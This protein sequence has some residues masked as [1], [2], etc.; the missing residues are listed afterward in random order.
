MLQLFLR[1]L[2]VRRMSL[3][4]VVCRAVRALFVVPLEYFVVGAALCFLVADGVTVAL[5]NVLRR[6]VRGCPVLYR[7][8]CRS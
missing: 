2:V 8:K 1:L 3:F 4:C 6:L 5:L 7:P